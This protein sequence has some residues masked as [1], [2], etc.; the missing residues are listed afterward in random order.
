MSTVNGQ[1]IKTNTNN[2]WGIM[3]D[4]T[5]KMSAW[6]VLE[7]TNSF[8]ILFY[9]LFTILRRNC[10]NGNI[11]NIWVGGGHISHLVV[12]KCVHI[13]YGIGHWH[14]KGILHIRTILNFKLLILTTIMK[15]LLD[16]IKSS[17]LFIIVVRI[18]S[19]KFKIVL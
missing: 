12:W 19:L 9:S 13:M 11:G 2:T 5:V 16:F 3:C 4:D 8:H 14:E 17:N 15:R 1:L 10:V 18:N 7:K 6:N